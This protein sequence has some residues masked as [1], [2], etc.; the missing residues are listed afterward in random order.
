MKLQKAMARAICSPRPVAQATNMRGVKYRV[1]VHPAVLPGPNLYVVSPK[2]E[3]GCQHA[4]QREAQRCGKLLS[5]VVPTQGV[6]PK[7]ADTTSSLSST[8]RPSS[9]APEQQPAQTCLKLKN[10][11]TRRTLAI[12]RVDD[13]TAS[14][15]ARQQAARRQNGRKFLSIA[16]QG[17]CHRI[18]YS[19]SIRPVHHVF[20]VYQS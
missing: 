10:G 19:T 8:D 1:R 16:T 3:E 15:A 11:S 20:P 2:A 5:W 18:V 14:C 17:A 7:R 12:F 9:L 6:I 13:R 4:A